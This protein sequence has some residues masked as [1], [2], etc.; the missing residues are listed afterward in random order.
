MLKWL[1]ALYLTVGSHGNLVNQK[2]DTNT[3]LNKKELFD[4]KFYY[5][6]EPYKVGTAC[7]DSLG[8]ALGQGAVVTSVIFFSV[9]HLLTNLYHI[10]YYKNILF[11]CPS[12]D[13]I[14][15]L[16]LN[17]EWSSISLFQ[18]ADLLY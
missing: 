15:H 6:D 2:R 14:D 17:I 1:T 9:L 4:S 11:S 3:N 8:F 10:I 7:N 13:Y 12:S 5:V 18:V 16:L